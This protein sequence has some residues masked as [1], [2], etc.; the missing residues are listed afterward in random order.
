MWTSYER[1]ENFLRTLLAAIDIDHVVGITLSNLRQ[2]QTF[3][4]RMHIITLQSQTNYS[5]IDQLECY[6]SYH[7]PM[8]F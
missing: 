1:R 3:Q 5:I 6:S 8:N 2:K 4:L 7:N